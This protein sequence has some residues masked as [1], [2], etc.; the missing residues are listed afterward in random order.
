MD[1]V[2]HAL[3]A[4]TALSL[5]QDMSSSLGKAQRLILD[6]AEGSTGTDHGTEAVLGSKA[7]SMSHHRP[8]ILYG[9]GNCH[10][11]AHSIL[12]VTLKGNHSSNILISLAGSNPGHLPVVAEHPLKAGINRCVAVIQHHIAELCAKALVVLAADADFFQPLHAQLVGISHLGALLHM[13]YRKG[14]HIQDCLL[15]L[16]PGL[17]LDIVLQAVAQGFQHCHHRLLRHILIVHAHHGDDIAHLLVHENR[18]RA[19]VALM[20]ILHPHLRAKKPEGLL[21]VVCHADT[22]GADF[23]HAHPDT[24]DFP[25]RHLIKGHGIAL[26]DNTF[27]VQKQ[28]ADIVFLEKIP[29]VVGQVPQVADGFLVQPL[30][31]S[32]ILPGQPVVRMNP[33]CR[34]TVGTAFR[35][36]SSHLRIYVGVR[37]ACLHI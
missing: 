29:Q 7:R 3:L 2:S 24:L 36:G 20:G 31:G 8:Q 6:R 17:L 14:Y 34:R 21:Q 33:V 23:L 30:P 9:H 16:Q 13:V 37:S 26:E 10:Y 1:A 32:K 19:G 27:L 5:Q 11:A 12:T 4:C 25:R 28:Q 15:S 22:A 18:C 35:P